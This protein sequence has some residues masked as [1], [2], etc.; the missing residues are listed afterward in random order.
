MPRTYYL[1]GS[2]RLERRDNTLYLVPPESRS[3]T[4][5]EKEQPQQPPRH[6]FAAE[7]LRTTGGRRITRR[8]P[9]PVEDV[10]QI[11]VFGELDLNSRLL[12]FL[13][14]HQ[15]PL[16]VFNYYGFYTGTF[17][18]REQNV[19]G[20]VRVRQVEHYL[21]PQ[22]RLYLA[23]EWVASALH[24]IRRNLLSYRRARQVDV[25]EA[26]ACVEAAQ[27]EAK[28]APNVPALMA[29]EGRARDAYYQAFETIMGGRVTFQR[30]V[31]RPPD[32]LVNALISFGNS[33]MYTAVLREI[34][35][36]Q[37]DPTLSYLHEPSSRRFALAL[38]IAENLQAACRRSDAVQPDQQT[39]AHRGRCG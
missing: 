27:D 24:H 8:R 39:R 7:L 3:V 9:I 38:D 36:T 4:E 30:R 37:L 15:I 11:Y 1:F 34:Y 26:L 17:Y 6:Q 10:E 14:Q 31:R 5:E 33:L 21:D 23:K 18:P 13:S 20:Y 35:L 32:N 25:D 29:A 2:G 16:H 28:S 12:S 22:R 19:S